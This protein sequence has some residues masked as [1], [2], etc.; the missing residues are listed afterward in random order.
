MRMKPWLE[1]VRLPNVLTA[2]ADVAAGYWLV[3]ASLLFTWRLAALCVAS[4]CLYAFGI[5]LNDLADIEVDRR[6]R[7]ARP[8]PSAALSIPAAQWLARVLAF[9]ALLMGIAA[10]FDAGD[11][12][13]ALGASYDSR[14]VAVVALLIA[15]IASYDLFTKGTPLGP[16]NMGL[17]RGLNLILGMC[18]GWWFSVDIGLLT[19]FAFTLYVASLTWFGGQEAG[20]SARWRLATGGFGIVFAIM[21]LGFLIAGNT[22]VADQNAGGHFILVMWLA[23]LVHMSRHVLR[24]IRHPNASTVQRAMKTFILGIIVLDAIIAAAAQ[25]WP[26]ALILLAL[27]IPAL[28]IGRW[29]YST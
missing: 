17:C 28:L 22:L 2:V 16:L 27:L 23:C 1:L 9:T 29:V 4:A 6:E 15:A 19:V 14:P 20:P 18:G 3:S 13:R 7:P 26:A 21:L 24:C 11:A 8:L 10:G 12:G 25:G 5:V